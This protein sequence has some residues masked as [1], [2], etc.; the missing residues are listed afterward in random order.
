MRT[1]LHLQYERGE[2]LT[3][4]YLEYCIITE[5]SLATFLDLIKPNNLFRP[6]IISQ[7]YDLVLESFAFR[8]KWFR[9][10]EK[11]RKYLGEVQ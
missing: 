4:F 10:V 9:E 11:N 5:R 2:R 7:S 6:L 3:I 1:V 8:G